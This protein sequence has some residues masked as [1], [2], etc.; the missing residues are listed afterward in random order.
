MTRDK[1]QL[2]DGLLLLDSLFPNPGVGMVRS[3]NR[4]EANL[5]TILYAL[6]RERPLGQAMLKIVQSSTQPD[7]LSRNAIELVQ[8]ALAKSVSLWL[9]RSGGW[10][11]ERFLRNESPVV[12]RVW[13]RTPPTELGLVFSAESLN[14]LMWLTACEP[15]QSDA[16]WKPEDSAELTVG[17]QVLLF[18]ALET[19]RNT[20]VG[21]KWFEQSQ[22]SGNPLVALHFPDQVSN[23]IG[24]YQLNFAPWMQGSGAA[25]LECLQS[26]LAA[27]WV[28]VERA[29]SQI[30]DPGK[31]TQVG[32]NQQ[33]I[34]DYFANAVEV[35]GRLDLSRFLLFALAEL[36]GEDADHHN[37]VR[38]LDVSNKRL[39]DRTIVYA[40]A[41]K[42][43]LFGKRLRTWAA[44][45]AATGYFDEGY[46]AAQLWLA[47]W[48]RYH[49]DVV[50]ARAAELAQRFSF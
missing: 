26:S 45:C 22:F 21:S 20:P 6:I 29:K 24:L 48:E 17:D 40:G 18:R 50:T 14:F 44:N 9:A 39:A 41:S 36:V 46:A 32:R 13:Q 10:Q 30:Q 7:C 1:N 38:S 2:K 8:Q 27:R 47:D 37:W 5:L 3:V 31:M 25:I 49:G 4:Y 11:V 42:F 34:L 33:L 35:S 19:L 28:A 12:G 16:E 43:L 23:D 15:L